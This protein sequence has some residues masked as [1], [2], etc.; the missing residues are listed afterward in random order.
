MVDQVK[1]ISARRA[2]EFRP[3]NLR[4]T[5]LTVREVVGMVQEEFDFRGVSITTPPPTFD[6]VPATIPPGLVFNVGAIKLN[7]GQTAPIRFMHFEPAR[8]VIDAAAPTS[9]IDEV[10]GRLSELL[11]EVRSPD[12]SLAM[13]EP[14][15]VRD[16]SE[17]SVRLY[18][19]FNQLLSEPVRA[20]ANQMFATEDN[21][22]TVP[23]T[24]ILQV[25]D[26]SLPLSRPDSGQAIVQVRAGTSPD[27]QIYF[28]STDLP[29]DKNVEWLK[30]LEEHLGKSD[31]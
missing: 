10:F 30:T 15:R 28:S 20:A 29:S 24:L 22:E 7:S 23:V 11:G 4:L 27:E 5:S 21:A 16:Y 26:T 8:V 17:V 25:A 13:G 19:R 9:A 18:G 6:D 12:G 3:D 31:Q 14:E 2:Y 1:V